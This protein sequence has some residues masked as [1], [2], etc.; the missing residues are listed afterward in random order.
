MAD[1][2]LGGTEL[3]GEVAHAQLLASQQLD[4]VRPHWVGE[5]AEGRRGFYINRHEYRL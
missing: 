1:E 5:C 2:R 3:L 4:D